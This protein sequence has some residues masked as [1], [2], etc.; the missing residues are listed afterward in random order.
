MRGGKTILPCFTFSALGFILLLYCYI[1]GFI[2]LLLYTMKEGTRMKQHDTEPISKSD[3]KIFASQKKIILYFFIIVIFVYL[4]FNSVFY[5]LYSANIKQI[6]ISESQSVVIKTNEFVNRTLESMEYTADIVQSNPVVQKVLGLYSHDPSLQ[7]QNYRDLMET[8][9]GIVTN[10]TTSTKSVD[11]YV[12]RDG[13]L[14]T[15]DYGLFS[16]LK[17]EDKKYFDMLQD[18]SE[19]YILTDLYRKNLTFILNRN[20]EQISFVRPVY[21]ISE[22]KKAGTLAINIDKYD[23]KKVIQGNSSSGSMLVDDYNN[24]LVEAFSDGSMFTRD[25]IIAINALVVG[26]SGVK[27]YKA[28]NTE[29]IVIYERSEYT[30]WRYVSIVPANTSNAQMSQLRDAILLLFFM[31][32]AISAVLLILLMQ[33]KIYR[34]IRTL[35]LSMKKVEK[36]DFNVSISDSGHDEFGYMYSSFNDMV[37]RIRNLFGELYEQKLLQK[38][39]E[40]KLL[41]SKINPHFIYNIFDN[42]NWLIQLERYDELEVLVDAVSNYYKK[43]LNAG[44]DYITISDTLEQLKDYVKIQQIRF[45]NRFTCDF[46]FDPEILSMTIPNFILQPLLENAICHGIEPKADLAHISVKGIKIRDRIFFTVEDNGVG[47]SND[48]IQ[49]VISYLNGEKDEPIDSFFALGNINKRIKIAYGDTYG[50]TIK[51]MEGAGT[52][53]TVFIPSEPAGI[54]EEQHA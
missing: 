46:D 49:E 4:V 42:M 48:K 7:A 28:D 36:G 38:E 16:T 37:D 17:W 2:I 31:M 53:V 6:V 13:K 22:G 14:I 11:L 8:L 32:S 18:T 33:A 20:Y 45:K 47:I 21:L 27:T 43:S 29:Y 23:L 25:Q 52:K 12:N 34:R 3:Y 54:R 50:L 35:I 9:Q 51:S 39:A 40:L 30:G 1:E 15:S 19:R 26:H 10:S 44:K 5:R 41:Q 24:I